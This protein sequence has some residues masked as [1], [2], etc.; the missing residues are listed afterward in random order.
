VSIV[1]HPNLSRLK[2]GKKEQGVHSPRPGKEGPRTLEDGD[3]IGPTRPAVW[4]KLKKLKKGLKEAGEVHE[5]R[6]KKGVDDKQKVARTLR[7][8]DREEEKTKAGGD[9]Q[10]AAKARKIRRDDAKS[11]VSK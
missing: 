3:R 4:I 7:N 2:P 10:K 5:N 1:N 11:G 6:E 9:L 8:Q